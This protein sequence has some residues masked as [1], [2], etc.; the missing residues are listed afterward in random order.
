MP[1]T[2]RQRRTKSTSPVVAPG[3]GTQEDVNN[4]ASN[5]GM[6]ASSVQAMLNCGGTGIGSRTRNKA[7][8]D[9]EEDAPTSSA[10][11]DFMSEEGFGDA[12]ATTA[13]GGDSKAEEKVE[14]SKDVT[15]G[16]GLAQDANDEDVKPI[17]IL[18]IV[19]R[20]AIPNSKGKKKSSSKSDNK[21]TNVITPGILAQTGTMDSQIIGRTKRP[22]KSASES[23][24]DLQAPTI[25][26]YNSIFNKIPIGFIAASSSSCHSIA[27]DITGKAY[28]WG[29]NELGQ[30]GVSGAASKCVG[31]PTPIKEVPKD[32][33]GNPRIF[34]GGAVGKSHSVLVDLEGK[35]FSVGL[36]KYGQCGVN[37][38]MEN[39]WN[40]K[41]GVLVCGAT[42]MG[43]DEEDMKE[44]GA[45][46]KRKATS[47]SD[48]SKSEVKVVQV[49]CG[50]NFTVLLTSDGH[51]YSAGLSEFGQLGNGETGEYFIAAN[52]IGFANASKFERRWEFVQSEADSSSHHSSKLDDKKKQ[53]MVVLPD[54]ADI[55]ISSISC[56]KNHAIAVEAPSSNNVTPR[57]FTWGC[58]G[59]GVLGHNVQA[60]EYRPRLVAGIRG[61]LFSS[62][63]PIR[64]AAGSQSSTI[65]TAHGHVYYWGRHRPNDEATMRPTLLDV[66]SNNGHVITAL[67]GGYQSIFCSSKNGVTISWGNGLVGELG[68][69]EGNPKSSSKPKFVEKLD[70]CLVTEVSCGYG[71]TLFLVRDEDAED[72]KARKKMSSIEMEDMEE[73]L[74]TIEK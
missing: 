20:M 3:G 43:E 15:N 33:T 72:K 49:S 27:I 29:R 36:N 8:G 73:Y 50:E 62:N 35:V 38:A 67:A 16:K 19:P 37:H 61:P 41:K 52:K 42:V 30:C 4:L 39:C 22:L 48:G 44:E 31:T 2:K 32:D 45:K 26:G 60:D 54:S 13:S 9:L 12:A 1:R 24:F 17:Y 58:G 59:Y 40:W 74:D 47:M 70:C 10:W 68:F 18:P 64:A 28:T 14:D 57:V 34:V 69:G 23:P 71:H 46:K 55:C 11:A 5:L 51:I 56:G 6:D 65:L 53:T 66:L 7:S 63:N 21:A 25:L